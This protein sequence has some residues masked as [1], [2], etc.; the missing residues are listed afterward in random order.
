MGRYLDEFDA[1]PAAGRWAKARHWLYEESLPFFAELRAE[2]P[3]LVTPEVT[4]ATTYSDC[5]LILR[6]HGIFGVD[7]YAPKQG[8]YW[9]AQD[10][11]ARHIREKSVMKAILDYEEVPKMRA[12][13]ATTAAKLLDDAGWRIE[14]VS[15]LTRAIPVALVQRWFGFTGA[16]PAKLIEWSYW[17]QQDAFHNQPFD[18]RPDADAIVAARN[19]AGLMFGLYLARLV[20]ARTIEVKLGTDDND[21][22]SRLLKL[23]FSGGLAMSFKQVLLNVGGLLIGAVET[24]NHTACNALQGLLQRP[25]V[26]PGAVAAAAE[27]D[28][29]AF[30]GYV[31]EALRFKPAFP[32]FFRTCH[33]PTVL[34]GGTPH[35]ATVQPGT[36]VLAVTHSA[37]FDE[38]VYPRPDVFDP[39][40]P[41][42]DSFTFG[43]GLHECLGMAIGRAM[44][45]EIVRQCLRLPNLRAV[46]PIGYRSG[47]PEVYNLA[48]G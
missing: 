30:D 22:V 26:L 34:S 35:A 36:T 47:V 42:G 2:R 38:A 37:M 25:D 8:P 27:D 10:E 13:I 18:H 9:M 45:S 33:A 23:Y 48:W 39:T 5:S 31:Y 29:A 46:A 6:N 20:A 7:L 14:A 17:N 16:D 3:V 19:K 32:Y 1:T 24:T 44:I 15:G 11:T 12:W 4:L 40:R 28:P 21:P 41:T 43:Q